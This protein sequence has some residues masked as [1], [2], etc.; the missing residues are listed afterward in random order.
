MRRYIF[1]DIDGVL[2]HNR[3]SLFAWQQENP[4]KQYNTFHCFNEE[5]VKEFNRIIT[6]TGA[7]VVLSSTWRLYSPVPGEEPSTKNLRKVLLLNGNV[8]C[9]IIGFTPDLGYKAV[10]G[11]YREIEK[12]IEEFGIT[13]EDRFIVLDDRNDAWNGDESVFIQTNPYW[14]LTKEDADRAIEILMS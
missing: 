3:F 6:E 9:N 5:C 2:N 8:R 1:L 10:F 12:S 14:G 11:R 13:N 7:N 4:G